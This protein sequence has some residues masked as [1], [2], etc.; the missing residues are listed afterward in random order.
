MSIQDIVKRAVLALG[1]EER[2]GLTA[3]DSSPKHNNGTLLKT[4]GVLPQWVA[5]KDGFGGA[6][7]FDGI[8]AYVEVADDP[9]LD[10][11]DE[12]T[13]AVWAKSDG[14][15]MAGG[16]IWRIIV[17]KENSY[18]LYYDKS[19]DRI[20]AYF[21][22]PD[23]GTYTWLRSDDEYHLIVMTYDGSYVHLYIDGVEHGL[24]VAASGSLNINANPVHVGGETDRGFNA[25]MDEVII[26]PYALTPTENR[27]LY[28]SRSAFTATPNLR[29]GLVLDMDFQEGAGLTAFDRSWYKNNG[30]LAAAPETPTWIAGGGLSFDG[31][32]D[33]VSIPA[34][35]ILDI[36]D[37]ITIEAM[38]KIDSIPVAT[39]GRIMFKY[40]SSA[41][42]GGCSYFLGLNSPCT[43][44]RYALYGAAGGFDHILPEDLVPDVETHLAVTWEKTE[45]KA[46]LYVNGLEK[47]VRD[48]SQSIREN[49]AQGVLL[50]SSHIHHL[51]GDIH[52]ISIYDRKIDPI[53]VR[54]LNNL[55]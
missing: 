2:T 41:S 51:T 47:A 25:I 35:P 6:L 39:N 16:S 11:A 8:G 23:Q 42:V 34:N 53:E 55:R 18:L 33:E 1:F 20:A 36:T 43:R 50:G 28:E 5:G 37:A 31:V 22:G 32:N 7:D 4:N 52:K 17:G 54:N 49:P 15:G 13:I 14:T 27:M 46:R 44:F 10:I 9:S 38:V 19:T 3:F 45:G 29:R 40:F 12:I 30:I 48:F 26:L 21:Y 24:P